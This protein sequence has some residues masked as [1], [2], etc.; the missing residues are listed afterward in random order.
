M[1]VNRR[2]AGIALSVIVVG[3]LTATIA[4]L[5]RASHSPREFVLIVENKSTLPV[6]QIKLFGT[7]LKHEALL[8]Q[9]LPGQTVSV[10]A[11][12]N[13]SGPLRVEVSQR[14]TRIDTYIAK[15]SAILEDLN[16]RLVIHDGNRFLIFKD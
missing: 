8:Q 9:L 7:A 5:W 6:E 11:A 4:W 3:S 2:L 1:R 16:Q 14:L 13:S 10:S 12:I 15:D